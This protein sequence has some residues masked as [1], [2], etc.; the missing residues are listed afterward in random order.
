MEANIKIG[1]MARAIDAMDGPGV[2]TRNLLDALVKI[3]NGN[4]YVVFYRTKKEYGRYA[5]YKNVKKM[6]LQIPTKILWDQ[7]A[8]P[9]AAF[10][11]EVDV[12]FNT[13]FT[14]PLLCKRPSITTL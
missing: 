6:V 12:I 7:I 10:R 13:K 14:V 4:E 3:D 8:V 5:K 9:L 1:V 11:E 2:G